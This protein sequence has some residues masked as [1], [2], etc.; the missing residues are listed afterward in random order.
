V[1]SIDT[2]NATATTFDT[3]VYLRGGTCGTGTELACNDDTL[4]CGVF[5]D[6]ANPRRGS[7]ITPTVVAGQTYFIVVDGYTVGG[8]FSL[9]VLPPP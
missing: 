1:A 3:V 8:A 4:G 9:Q 2:C 5:G 7:R 6:G